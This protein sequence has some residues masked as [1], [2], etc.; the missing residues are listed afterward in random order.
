MEALGQA[1]VDLEGMFGV[2]STPPVL[3]SLTTYTTLMSA[4]QNSYQSYPRYDYS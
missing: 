1:N 2:L 4:G 3:N